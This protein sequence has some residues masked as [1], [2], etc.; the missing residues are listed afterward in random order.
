MFIFVGFFRILFGEKYISGLV[1]SQLAFLTMTNI[2]HFWVA[3]NSR[4]PMQTIKTINKLTIYKAN[5]P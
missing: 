3:S 5:L 1:R 4:Q 2:R